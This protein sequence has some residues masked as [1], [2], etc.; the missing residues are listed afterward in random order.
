MR[1]GP[2]GSA[3][4][5]WCRMC[6]RL[7]LPMTQIPRSWWRGARRR[8]VR[9]VWWR[10]LCVSQVAR[11]RRRCT[12]CGGAA[13][14]PCWCGWP[15]HGGVPVCVFSVVYVGCFGLA[16]PLTLWKFWEG[17]ALLVGWFRGDL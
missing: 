10:C 8:P 15:E 2:V 13:R 5:P 9:R 6:R 11:V 4:I 17:L 3:G 16:T 7:L 14:R 1:L 12:L